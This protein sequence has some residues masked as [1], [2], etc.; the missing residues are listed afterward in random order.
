MPAAA[1]EGDLGE[2]SSVP[3]SRWRPDRRFGRRARSTRGVLVRLFILSTRNATCITSYQGRILGTVTSC[4]PSRHCRA[5]RCIGSSWG[6][7]PFLQPFLWSRKYEYLCHRR[8]AGRPSPAHTDYLLTARTYLQL[9]P[10]PTTGRPRI[11]KPLPL[12]GTPERRLLLLLAGPRLRPPLRLPGLQAISRLQAQQPRQFL[13]QAAGLAGPA[14]RGRDRV[15]AIFGQRE[16][17]ELAG[18]AATITA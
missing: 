17:S 11:I 8:G 9:W 3:A 10:L 12:A 16:Q 6:I 15:R 1:A 4:F 7:L 14:E 5:D 2:S 13:A 18:L